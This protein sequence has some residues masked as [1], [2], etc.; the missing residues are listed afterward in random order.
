MGVALGEERRFGGHRS[1]EA[2]QPMVRRSMIAEG[3]MG[4]ASVQRVARGF[5][6]VPALGIGLHCA[7][8]VHRLGV[9]ALLVS[10]HGAAER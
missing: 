8:L 9:T 2:I 4:K 5:S 10:A 7:E 1:I 6:R 3:E